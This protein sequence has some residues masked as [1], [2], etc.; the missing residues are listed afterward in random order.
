MIH[1]PADIIRELL[2]DKEC[3]SSPDDMNNHPWPIFVAREPSTPDQN[4][5]VYNTQGVNHGRVQPTGEVIQHCGFQCLIR[6]FDTDIGYGKAEQIRVVL[7]EDVNRELV[8]IHRLGQADQE[9][10]VQS[11][12]QKSQINSLGK[13][14]T[15]L[16]CYLFTL[17]YTTVISPIESGT[18]T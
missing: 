12:S 15:N 1:T 10:I 6:S 5:T 14:R 9:Y 13:D 18:G 16:D 7:N 8:L 3:G 4:I 11:C 2:I 17:N